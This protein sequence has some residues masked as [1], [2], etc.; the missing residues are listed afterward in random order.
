MNFNKSQQSAI[1]HKDGP[2]LVLAG[3]GS[4]KTAVITHRTYNLIE[5]Y[6]V[7]PSEILV[8]TFTKAASVEMKERFLRLAGEDK[9]K[10]TF[11]TFH[12][13]F[14]M[15]LKHAYHFSNDNVITGEQRYQ[16]MREIIAR[17]EIEYKDE[18]ECIEGLFAEISNVKNNCIDINNFYSSQCGEDIFRRIYFDY[19]KKLKNARLIDFDDML[20]YT[21][22]LFKERED[23]L[24]AWQNKYRYILIDECQDINSM[25]YR[26]IQMLAL[27]NNNLFIVGDDDQSIYRFRGAVPEI[28]LNFEKDYPNAEKILLDT[29]YRCGKYIVDTAFNL[30]SHNKKRFEK[31][32][33][34]GSLDQTPVEY[35]T[36]ENQRSENLY[37]IMQIQALLKQGIHLQDIAILVRTNTQPRKLMEQLMEFNIAFKVKDQISNIY[38]HW[39]ARDLFTYMRIAKGSR[40][41]EDLL[42]I[43]NRPQRYIG[44]DSLREA[45]VSWEGWSGYY[46]RQPWIAERIE[47]LKYDVALLQKMNPYA[48]IN[49]IRKGIG[50]EE[51]LSGYGKRKGM[52]TEELFHILDEIQESAKGYTDLA[53]WETHIQEFG[54]QIRNSMNKDLQ[55]ADVVTVATLHSSKGLEFEVVFI[56][57]VNEGIMPYKKAVLENEIEE[58][59][60][61][62]Y[63]G[64]TRAKRKLSLYSVQSIHDKSMEI[65][66]FIEE[67]KRKAQ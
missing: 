48:A 20:G 32:I 39:I 64:M 43:M 6:Q 42:Q 26:I 16:F 60:R 3:P 53:Q 37:L 44:R 17:Y 22:E 41:R 18:G 56:L 19:Q 5:R 55:K 23:I 4:G 12:A 35:I 47:K 58:E 1:W 38:E 24:C 40:S 8:I 66:R 50:Y 45:E 63:V 2:M 9:T 29:N 15:I 30:I 7:N 25:Q 49:Y 27:P 57:D 31:K 13:V 36:F 46:E 67:T 28:M 51:Y 61:L 34:T 10:V 54:E 33:L 11:G 59:R 62:F 21:F 65:S 52:N 14:F